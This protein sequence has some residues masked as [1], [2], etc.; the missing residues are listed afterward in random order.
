MCINRELGKHTKVCPHNSILFR[1]TQEPASNT[2]NITALLRQVKE[3]RHKNTQ[4]VTLVPQRQKKMRWALWLPQIPTRRKFPGCKGSRSQCT[5]WNWVEELSLAQQGNRSPL[6][7]VLQNRAAQSS[8][9][10]QKGPLKHST[11][12]WCVVCEAPTPLWL[13]LEIG[14]LKSN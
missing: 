14:I 7:K 6:A 10:L 4:W 1:Y 3:V 2:H 11:E 8:C 13:Y 12:Y 5:A 9:S